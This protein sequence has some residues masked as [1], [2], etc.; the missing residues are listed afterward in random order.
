MK[1]GVVVKPIV[2]N[3]MNKRCQVDCIDMQSS[4][5]GDFRYIMVYQDHGTKFTNL[6]ALETKQAD[7]IASHLVHIF[8]NFGSPL[9][10]QSD[11]G[12]EFVN[13][14]IC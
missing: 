9:F 13:Q 11:N 1:K 14:C 10:L 6:R 12:R 5:D 8:C 4:P 3:G 2:T 7:E